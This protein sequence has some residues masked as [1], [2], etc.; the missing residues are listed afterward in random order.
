MELSYEAALVPASSISVINK[1][2]KLV[3]T[4][5]QKPAGKE[6][7]AQDSVARQIA[8]SHETRRKLSAARENV[9]VKIL[10]SAVNGSTLSK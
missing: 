2:L 10:L 6:W 7:D 1:A 5:R 3:C 4:K 9:G 8:L